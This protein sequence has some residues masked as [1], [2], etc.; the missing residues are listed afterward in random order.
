[1][2]L[3]EHRKVLN[4]TLLRMKQQFAS[5]EYFGSR[6]DT[7]MAACE[8]EID[9]CTF[10]I[11]IYAWRYG[12]VPPNRISSI[13]EQEFDYAIL[14]KKKCLCY[15]ADEKYGWMPMYIDK[16]SD[17]DR[18]ILFKSK[19][20]SLVRSKFSTPDN[21]AKQAA[22]D[23][24]REI[25][26]DKMKDILDKGDVSIQSLVSDPMLSRIKNEVVDAVRNVLTEMNFVG[27]QSTSVGMSAEQH[28]ELAKLETGHLPPTIM[29]NTLKLTPTTGRF[30]FFG[31]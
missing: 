2:D 9:E 12:W 10:F 3:E 1:M 23:I 4:D 22:A 6:T 25:I 15:I 29:M 20:S 24:S 17:A 7:P 14:K 5:M 27:S 11:G 8:K 30:I 13:T 31:R 18:L 26:A 16:G 21:L 19:V 28:L